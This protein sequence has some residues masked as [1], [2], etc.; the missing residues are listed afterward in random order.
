[1][2]KEEF[3]S[4]PPSQVVPALA[5]KGIYLGSESTFYRIL[6]DHKQNNHRGR[7]KTAVK[8]DIPSH[9]AN[10]PLEIWVT[11]IERHEAPLDRVEMKGLHLGP[12]AAGPMKL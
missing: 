6:R 11:D 1:M 12:V 3:S 2:H 7:A 5:D 8:R 4:L 10:A 9:L